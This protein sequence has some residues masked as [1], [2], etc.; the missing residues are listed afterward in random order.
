ME[1]FDVTIV[2]AGVVGLAIA[3]EIPEGNNLVIEKHESFGKETSSRNSEVIHAGIYYPNGFLKSKMCVEGNEL[4]YCI[5]RENGI[6][7]KN[8]TKIIVAL[9]SDEEKDLKKLYQQGVDNGVPGL[10]LI[11]KDE[12]KKLEPN[13]NAVS[14]LFS[15]STG[16]I[17]THSIMKHF[18]LIAKK[19]GATFAYG[20]EVVAA[21]KIISGYKITVKDT[22][23]ESYDFF[24]RTLINCAGLNSDKVANMLGLNEYKIYYCKGE[25]FSV[26][27]GKGRFLNRLV[28]PH[29]TSTSLGVHTVLDL[30]G[31]LKLGPNAF[32]VDEVNYDVD[33][34][35]AVEMWE[36][37]YKFLP[38]IEKND[39]SPDMSGIRPK[40]QK[41][42]ESM[43]DFIIKHEYEKGFEGFINLIGIESPGLTSSPAIARYVRKILKDL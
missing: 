17:D 42:G 20:C 43:K 32:Y 11:L 41:E 37:A 38:F 3:S 10:R 16:I 31:Q 29:P 23:G 4:L 27:G 39:L 40:I 21:E 8:I 13:I 18:E 25:Y 2:G 36:S 24:T 9:D 5:C 15:P 12:V 35:H 22:D 26:A 7:H 28:Y 30:Q 1:K 33:P 6:N 34:G 19:K 14:G